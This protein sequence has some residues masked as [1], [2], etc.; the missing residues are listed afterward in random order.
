MRGEGE[1]DKVILFMR[2][3]KHLPGVFLCLLLGI[4]AVPNAFAALLVYEGF[5]YP[6]GEN[7]TNSSAVSLGNSF[8]W[9]GR[10]TAANTSLATNSAG[11][12][13]YDDG[14]GHSLASDGGKVVVG[15]PAGT[16][17]N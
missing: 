8:G 7:V 6:A 15:V 14:N 5:N 13:G 10:W 3:F 12:L 2:S 11:N 1:T 9:A 16:T 17:G 4:F